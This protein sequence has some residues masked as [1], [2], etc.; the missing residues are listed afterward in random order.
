MM[1][2]TIVKVVV[3]HIVVYHLM[4]EYAPQLLFRPVIVARDQDLHVLDRTSATYFNEAKHTQL[5]V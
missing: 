2:L 5:G 1:R 3:L 4:H